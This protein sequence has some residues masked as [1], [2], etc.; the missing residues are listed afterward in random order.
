ML[1]TRR[2]LLTAAS[3]T[4]LALSVDPLGQTLGRHLTRVVPLPEGMGRRLR[5]SDRDGVVFVVPETGADRLGDALAQW[6]SSPVTARRALMLHCAVYGALP[7][8]ALGVGPHV[9][10]LLVTPRAEAV[11]GE[12]VPSW[13]ADDIDHAVQALLDREPF[14]RR[15][16][17]RVPARARRLATDLCQSLHDDT[18]PPSADEGAAAAPLLRQL[19]ERLPG[20]RPTLRLASDLTRRLHP[21]LP[22]DGPPVIHGVTWAPVDPYAWDCAGPR[23]P[24]FVAFTHG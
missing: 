13:C 8:R 9:Q 21:G 20:H 4:P 23:P 22:S 14:V 2:A 7:Q 19:L 10:V 1:L 17:R 15:R 18:R 16:R 12:A 11:A 24:R 5:A 6:L 3:L